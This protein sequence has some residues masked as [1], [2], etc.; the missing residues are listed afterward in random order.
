MAKR[1]PLQNILAPLLLPLSMLYGLGGALCRRLARNGRLKQWKPPRP[2]VSVGNISWGGT[3]KTPVTDWLL[4][5]ASRHGLRAA[6]LTR[7]YGAHP[8]TLPL[9]AAPGV[10]PSACGDEPL[11]LATAHPDAVIMVD[12]DRS[13]AGRELERSCPPDFYILDDGFQHLSTG[14]D[15]DLVLLDRDDVLLHPDPGRPPSNWNRIIPA[16][17]WREPESALQDAGAYLIKTEPEEWP[18]LVSALPSRLRL[19][20]RPVF[21]FRMAPKGLRPLNAQAGARS[22]DPSPDSVPGEYVFV[23]GIGNPAQALH[24][25]T[26]FLGRAPK[27]MLTFPDHHDFSKDRAS[28]ET[29]HLPIVCTA[30]DAVKLAP[31]NLSLPCF[32]LEVSAEFF[33]SLSAETVA[34]STAATCPDFETW[35]SD[36]LTRHLC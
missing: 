12:P 27:T 23:C 6:V 32:S 35:W 15:L 20:P 19:W 7:G 4:D 21:A 18:T 30:K 10:S 3:G 1:H 36:W 34:G 25:V 33:A 16:G 22:T 24:T 29:M 9:R 11:M 17:T 2:C 14:R 26:T 5:H 8:S 28:L 13:R 31:L